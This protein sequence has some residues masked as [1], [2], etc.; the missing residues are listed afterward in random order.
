MKKFYDTDLFVYSNGLI[1]NSVCVPENMPLKKIEQL[2]NKNNPSGVMDWKI[3]EDKEFIDGTPMP[4]KCDKYP[5]EK[6]LH[7]L[8]NC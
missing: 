6:R 1:F 5:Q 4:N 8:L 2:T 7:Y 3:S